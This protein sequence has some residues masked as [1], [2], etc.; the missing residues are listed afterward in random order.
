MAIIDTLKSQHLSIHKL[1]IEIGLALKK[2]DAAGVG[3]ALRELKPM[4]VAHHALEDREI[5]PTLIAAGKTEEHAQLAA[6]AKLFADNMQRISE[7]MMA[8]FKRHD[9]A[10]LDLQKFEPDFKSFTGLIGS[11]TT[12]EETTLYP[13][14]ERLFAAVPTAKTERRLSA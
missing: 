3:N 10:A 8:F 1:I 13:I 11:R 14:Y 12:A 9:P 4:L 5:Y 6:T 2:G 7:G